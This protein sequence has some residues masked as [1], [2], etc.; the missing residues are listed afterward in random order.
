MYFIST[1]VSYSFTSIP[2]TY[3]HLQIRGLYNYNSNSDALLALQFNSDTGN[4]Y[5]YHGLLGDGS[6]VS[7]SSAANYN[8]ILSLYSYPSYQFNTFNAAIIDIIDYTSTNKN[9]T[10]RTLNGLDANGSGKV[11]L[12]SGAWYNTS[13]INSITV[14]SVASHTFAQYST[15]ALYGVR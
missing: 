14:T 5:S 4:N 15:F 1:G 3:K 9:K 7:A 12:F 10:V 11:G 13:A 8:S 2:S 6:T